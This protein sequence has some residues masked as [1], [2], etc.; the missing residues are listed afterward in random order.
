M[1]Y[2]VTKNRAHNQWLSSLFSICLKIIYRA[3]INS[4]LRNATLLQGCT[5][6]V[7]N[8]GSLPPRPPPKGGSLQTS[9]DCIA[10]DLKG[11]VKRGECAHQRL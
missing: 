3:Y 4:H 5:F 6:A 1:P 9:R 2:K 10:P 11:G 8:K 7:E